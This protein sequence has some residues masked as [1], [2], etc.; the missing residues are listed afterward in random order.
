MTYNLYNCQINARKRQIDEY[1]F[2]NRL[3]ILHGNQIKRWHIFCINFIFLILRKDNK[4][5]LT[6]ITEVIIYEVA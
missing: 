6:K 2:P 1:S 4:F 5:I 3:K